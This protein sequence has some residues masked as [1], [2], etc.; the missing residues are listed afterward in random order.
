MDYRVNSY[1]EKILIYGHNNNSL[2]LPFSILE[3]YNYEEYDD[4][5]KYLVLEFEEITLKYEIFPYI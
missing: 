2:S 1:S 3:N 4:K 5:H